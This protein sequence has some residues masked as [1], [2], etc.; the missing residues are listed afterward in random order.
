M[1]NTSGEGWVRRGGPHV[2]LPLVAML[3]SGCFHVGPSAKQ[4]MTS[5]APG[6][7]PPVAHATGPKAEGPFD[8]ENP[9]VQN[10]VAAFQTHLRGFFGGALSRGA[11]YL[12]S[13]TD[14]LV[15]EG[16]PAELAYLPLI[17][18]G[19]RPQ[20][21]SPAGAAGPWQFIPATGRRYGLR[22]DALVD[23][24]RDPIKSTHAASLY[25][26]DLHEMFG[27]WELSLAAYN[28]GEYRVA[29]ILAD[30]KDVD[31]FWD[32]RE[33]GYLPSETSAYVPSFLAAVQIARAPED[34][35]FETPTHTPEHV[36]TVDIERQVSLR[37]AADFC[38]VSATELAELNPAL[39]SGVT[40]SGYSLRVPAG[41]AEPLRVGLATY[42]EPVHARR[43]VVRSTRGDR[44]IARASRGVVAVAQGKKSAERVARTA[45]QPRYRRADNAT[46]Q[47]ARSVAAPTREAK[48]TTESRSSVSAKKTTINRV[49]ESTSKPAPAKS[50]KAPASRRPRRG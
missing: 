29:R 36:E 42:V 3:V 49:V 11:K 31:D 13:M 19:F 41:K 28:S 47:A 35:G 24:R 48:A 26:K 46:V 32:M 40:P 4:A 39:R 45:P 23:E 43:N 37:A 33:R 30:K 34:Y 8:L 50:K 17:E 12:P 6:G 18:S 2:L 25:L 9:A 10:R 22:I 44:S 20:A 5:A 15:R 27:D 38:G 14:I 7:N 16:L 21:V 1:T